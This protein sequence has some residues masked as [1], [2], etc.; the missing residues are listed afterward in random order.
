VPAERIDATERAAAHERRKAF[1]LAM[2][3]GEPPP[4]EQLERRH[5]EPIDE[6]IAF[7]HSSEYSRNVEGCSMSSEPVEESRPSSRFAFS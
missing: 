7:D 4:A 6:R 3:D 1:E 2:R 5:P